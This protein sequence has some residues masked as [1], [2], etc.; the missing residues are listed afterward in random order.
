MVVNDAPILTDNQDDVQF[1]VHQ[2]FKFTY[3]ERIDQILSKW[4]NFPLFET[5]QSSQMFQSTAT[6]EPGCVCSRSTTIL[7][8]LFETS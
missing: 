5:F 3:E 1:Q 6:A 7:Y 4:T 2:N 8:Q